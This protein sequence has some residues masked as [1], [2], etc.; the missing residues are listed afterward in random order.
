MKNVTILPVAVLAIWSFG[1]TCNSG[2]GTNNL[3]IFPAA[4]LEYQMTNGALY[5]LQGTD[6]LQGPWSNSVPAILG[7][8]SSE[9]F[10]Q[11]TRGGNQKFWRVVEGSP[12]NL[13][14]FSRARSLCSTNSILFENVQWQGT[15]YQVQYRVGSALHQ[16]EMTPMKTFQIPNANISVDGN[17]SDWSTIPVLYGDPQHDQNPPDGHPGTDIKQFKMA[18]DTNNIYM[19]FW[20]YDADPPQDGTIYMTELQLYLNQMN[21]P[22]D[23]TIIASY[24][25]GD[26]EWQVQIQHREQPSTGVKYGTAYVGVGTKFIEYRIPVADVEYFGGS[27]FQYRMGIEGRFIRTYVHYVHDDDVND[28][29]ST[30]D[31]AGEDQK[32]MVIKFY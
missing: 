7:V 30:Y 20:L 11:S 17:S 3:F 5:Q 18:R 15:N 21:M 23:T 16:T 19:A 9:S 32:V 22:G 31:G 1:L 26:A 14:D 27:E 4:E 29:L 2:A 6:N 8:N 28:P 24:S 13:M 12:T 10:L 25:A